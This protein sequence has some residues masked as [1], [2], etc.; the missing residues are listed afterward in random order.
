MT[1]SLTILRALVHGD[2]ERLR[3]ALEC[4]T[5]S[6]WRQ[7]CIDLIT[8]APATV[9]TDAAHSCFTE[10]GH[11]VR[12]KVDDDPLLVSVLRQLLPKV[13]GVPTG[14]G[15]VLYRGENFDRYQAGHVG[16]CWSSKR[17][18][19]EMFG[20]GLNAMVGQG[21]VLLQAYAPEHALLARP[22]VHS[23]WLGEEEHL[24]DPRLLQDVKPIA[25]YPNLWVASSS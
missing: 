1:S 16:L 2:R 12:E 6:K 9:N 22:N 15:I 13:A 11:L 3:A 8:D 19:A 4:A 25:Q 7:A 20:A 17:A 10:F 24:V 18:V 14:E 23:R 21:G 5:T